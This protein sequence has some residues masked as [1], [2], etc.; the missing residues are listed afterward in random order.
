MALLPFQGFESQW[1]VHILQATKLR[2]HFTYG[3]YSYRLRRNHGPCVRSDVRHHDIF[4]FNGTCMRVGF[5]S[6]R[7]SFSG[8]PPRSSDFDPGSVNV[9][10]GGHGANLFY[11]LVIL[12]VILLR[13][14]RPPAP[15]GS[16]ALLPPIF[17]TNLYINNIA[18]R[19]KNGRNLETFK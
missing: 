12:S 16:P 5:R 6:L 11:F 2:D 7:W 15:P 13:T 19:R 17:H 1:Q 4:F 8:L 3:F 10:Y 9:R 14:I 18:S